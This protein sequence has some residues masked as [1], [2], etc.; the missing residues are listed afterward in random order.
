MINILPLLKNTMVVK[1][2]LYYPKMAVNYRGKLLYNFGFWFSKLFSPLY[3]DKSAA[4]FQGAAW[5]QDMF[6]NFY[7]GQNHQIANVSTTTEAR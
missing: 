6:C 7:F 4:I 2:L 1:I 5:I 3:L